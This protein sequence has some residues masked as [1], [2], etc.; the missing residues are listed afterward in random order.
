MLPS[1]LL[2]V[3][4]CKRWAAGRPWCPEL[5]PVTLLASS[6]NGLSDNV[7]NFLILFVIRSQV[8]SQGVISGTQRHSPHPFP[9]VGIM[10]ICCNR[11]LLEQRRMFST[12]SSVT[13]QSLG[14]TDSVAHLG[15]YL[16]LKLIH[17]SFPHLGKAP[18]REPSAL[19]TCIWGGWNSPI[20]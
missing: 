4:S 15:W 10:C 2:R 14:T 11:S 20:L 3:Y 19:S 1:F 12:G 13:Q 8:L 7:S 9:D 5:S 17:N 16:M 18:Q 6:T